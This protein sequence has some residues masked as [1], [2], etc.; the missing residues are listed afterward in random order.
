LQISVP[1]E[2]RTTG[3]LWIEPSVCAVSFT[4]TPDAVAHTHVQPDPQF[5]PVSWPSFPL[6]AALI[7]VDVT[8]GAWHLPNVTVCGGET[9]PVVRDP[10]I[11]LIDTV[12]LTLHP[13]LAAPEEV[14]LHPDGSVPDGCQKH[15][16]EPQFEAASWYEPELPGVDTVVVVTTGHPVAGGVTESVALP[17]AKLLPAITVTVAAGDPQ[18]TDSRP[19]EDTFHP[20]GSA[21]AALHVQPAL[22]Q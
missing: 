3:W 5:D 9:S 4:Q 21:P 22:G 15:P 8:A 6:I 14:R 12:L 2:S 16:L 1:S 10:A 19:V 17:K 20:E 18:T 13:P 7:V 11:T